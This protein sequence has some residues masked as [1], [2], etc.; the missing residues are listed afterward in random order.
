L[1]IENAELRISGPAV[2]GGHDKRENDTRFST[3]FP[4]AGCGFSLGGHI[5]NSFQMSVTILE[6]FSGAC[7]HPA[8]K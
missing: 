8:G 2:R 3:A 5:E 6:R 1:R 7:D 4:R